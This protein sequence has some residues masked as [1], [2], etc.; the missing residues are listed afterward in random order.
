MPVS[1]GPN[2][3]AVEA[4]ARKKAAQDEAQVEKETKKLDELWKDDDKVN[5]AKL[6]RKS[7][8]HQKAEEQRARKAENKQIAD[9]EEKALQ[10]LG[11]NRQSSRG[12]DKKVNRADIAAA[13][14][15]AI[16]VASAKLNE[17]AGGGKRLDEEPLMENPNQLLRAQLKEAKQRGEN[18]ITA[19]GLD[20]A[21]NAL[22]I[23]ES[24][25]AGVDR[26]P[27]KRMKAA[28]KT[29]EDEY[30]PQ[31]KLENPTL[32]RSQLL[33]L[34]QKQWKKAPDNPLNRS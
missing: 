17:E 33:D 27:E 9:E 24:S 1:S 14:A 30:M 15:A 8:S 2:S 7:E 19:S 25:G 34:L 31:L 13:R 12:N 11:K 16:A 32:K 3:R 20:D 23:D 29:Y 26:N 6:N 21:V 18:L 22:Q 28:Y 5:M 10:G 4:R